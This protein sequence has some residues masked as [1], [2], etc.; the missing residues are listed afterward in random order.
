MP[1]SPV[2]EFPRQDAAVK[3]K[4]REEEPARIR[5][6]RQRRAIVSILGSEAFLK[7]RLPKALEDLCQTAALALDVARVS[8]WQWGTDRNVLLCLTQWNQGRF[9]T[10]GQKLQIAQFPIYFEA[11]ERDHRIEAHDVRRHPAVRQLLDFYLIPMGI[12]SMLDAGILVDGRLAGVVCFEHVGD[13]RRWTPDELSFASTTAALAGLLFA[14][15][16]RRRAESEAARMQARYRQLVDSSHDVIFTLNTDGQVTFASPQ[17]Q[18]QL[19][20]DIEDRVLGHHFQEFLHEEDLPAILE[21]WSL[22]L[23]GKPIKEVEYRARHTNGSW[24]RYACNASPVS[25]E[26][27]KVDFFVCSARDITEKHREELHRAETRRMESIGRLAGGVAHEFN[28]ML[29]VILGRLELL[30]DEAGADTAFTEHIGEIRRAV[31]RSARLTSQ[32]LA[33]AQRQTGSPQKIRLHAEIEKLQPKLQAQCSP[34]LHIHWHPFDFE[35]V[36]RFDSNWLHEIITSL[37]LRAKDA[38]K[39]NRGQVE[40]RTL[41]RTQ[42]DSR[43]E[44][45]PLHEENL[46]PGAYAQIDVIDNA[47]PIPENHLPYLFDP[48]SPETGLEADAGMRLASAYGMVRQGN[49]FLFVRRENAATVFSIFLPL[50]DSVHT[51]SSNPVSETQNKPCVL[52]VD[53]ETAITRMVQML[54]IRHGICAITASD[55]Q[56]A[57]KLAEE[58][59]PRLRVL[60][61]DIAMPQVNGFQLADAMRERVPDIYVI[62]MS[63]YPWNSIRGDR[64]LSRSETFLQKP[65]TL[66]DMMAAVAG[67]V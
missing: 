39:E 42:N 28:N 48:F 5:V 35:P 34:T 54:L 66:E 65:F 57:L 58:N 26:N 30:E 60:I 6:E 53:D 44:D 67:R 64:M 16:A 21:K 56:T 9:E 49:G 19:G 14:Q 2:Q 24:R 15:A 47:P 40:I 37:C 18:A 61:S 52:V 63:G 7:A 13:P 3:T 62:Y 8:V 25:S 55:P 20:Y 38:M 23:Q 43:E 46:P 22:A 17:W 33:Y 29:G 31:T 51:E 45:A 50:E 41:L 32:L 12:S 27:G 10:P 36:V 11:L 4:W 59:G 1:N